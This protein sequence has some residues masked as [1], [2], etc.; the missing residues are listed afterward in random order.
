MIPR[1][2]EL[3]AEE[4]A[5]P[6]EGLLYIGDKGK[7][8]SAGRGAPRLITA[9]G[10]QPL[11]RETPAQPDAG[12][13]PAAAGQTA[14]GGR[15][16]VWVEAFQGGTPSP[17]NFL[18]AGPISETVCLAAVALRAGRQKSGSRSYPAPLKLLYDSASMKV[19]NM[20]E[21]NQYLTREYRPGWEL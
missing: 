11:W 1:I 3:D 5:V 16:N 15:G 20:A 9:R 12:S 18:S 21:A 19:T 14:S 10:S 6:P 2:A 13:G 17:G 8:L 4:A 7:I